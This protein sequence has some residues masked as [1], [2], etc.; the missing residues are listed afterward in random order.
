MASSASSV[1]RG[2]GRSLRNCAPLG[3]VTLLSDPHAEVF[4]YRFGIYDCLRRRGPSGYLGHTED[5]PGPGCIEGE[6]RCGVVSDEA[7]AGTVV[8][9][10]ESRSEPTG[11]RWPERIVTRS[12]ATGRVLHDFSLHVATQQQTMLEEARA[13]PIAV[14]GTGAVAW[15]QEDWFA[16]HDGATP[17]PV[18]YDVFAIDSDGSHSLRTDLSIEPESLKIRGRVFSWTQEG[19]LQSAALDWLAN[20]RF[21]GS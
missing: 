9:Y 13:L 15:I 21:R 12:I 5:V 4:Q 18:V 1:A 2:N 7:L 3:A 14:N 10:A 11:G 6:E 8:A 17:P 16:R 19:R 20:P